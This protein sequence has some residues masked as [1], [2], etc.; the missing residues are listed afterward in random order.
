MSEKVQ[1]ENKSIF[2]NLSDAECK[3]MI[4][5]FNQMREQVIH[6]VTRREKFSVNLSEVST[7]DLFEVLKELLNRE[8]Q[9]EPLRTSWKTFLCFYK[10][11]SSWIYFI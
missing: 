3:I 6:E 2:P 5:N 9:E 7:D 10:S 4:T 11:G 8:K 1:E